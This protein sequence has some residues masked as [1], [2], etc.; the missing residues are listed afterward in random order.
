M[1]NIDERIDNF[2]TMP[3]GM[4][5]FGASRTEIKQLIRDVLEYV[6][7]EPID[8]KMA[9]GMDVKSHTAAGR[10]QAIR[11]MEAKQKELGL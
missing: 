5:F 8:V 9:F 6:K 4:E 10:N 7:P 2:E 1:M 3:V 11:Y